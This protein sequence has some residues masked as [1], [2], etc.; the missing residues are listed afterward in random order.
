MRHRIENPG[1]KEPGKSQNKSAGP[2]VIRSTGRNAAG[3]PGAS[4][5]LSNSRYLN[6]HRVHIHDDS[7][8]GSCNQLSFLTCDFI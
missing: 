2:R 3:S 1:K 5:Q 6:T 4:S 8:P 7:R